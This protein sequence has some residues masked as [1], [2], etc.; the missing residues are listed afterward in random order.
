MVVFRFRCPAGTYPWI[1]GMLWAGRCAY[2]LDPSVTAASRRSARRRRLHGVIAAGWTVGARMRPGH[3]RRICRRPTRRVK[4]IRPCALG[5]PAY[6]CEIEDFHRGN[7]GQLAWLRFETERQ[8]PGAGRSPRWIRVT[9]DVTIPS[10]NTWRLRARIASL[11]LLC[12]AGER[13]LALIRGLVSSRSSPT[14]SFLPNGDYR[15]S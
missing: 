13:R 10:S 14:V 5:S 4:R 6:P 1:D 15:W 8:F 12:S 3:R 11:P 7:V 9:Q 2:T